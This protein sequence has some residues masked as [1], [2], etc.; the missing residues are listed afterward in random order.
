[1][2]QEW[3]AQCP[4]TDSHDPEHAPYLP[5]E[6]EICDRCLLVRNGIVEET[7][8]V[9][10]FPIYGCIPASEVSAALRRLS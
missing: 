7:I 1:M 10:D 8:T 9:G 6:Y 3:T 5:R 4:A 2:T